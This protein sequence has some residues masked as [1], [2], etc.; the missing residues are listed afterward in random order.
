[1][2]PTPTNLTI[3]PNRIVATLGEGVG[4]LTGYDDEAGGFALED[5]VAFDQSPKTVL[6]L[7]RAGL[8]EAWA[9]DYQYVTLHITKAHP[10][11]CQL[12]LLALRLEFKEYPGHDD[13]HE[14]FVCHRPADAGAGRALDSAPEGARAGG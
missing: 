12:A 11:A 4:F 5:V 1:M 6:T 10:K 13:R 14:Y 8:A 7:V 9:R 2:K 3:R